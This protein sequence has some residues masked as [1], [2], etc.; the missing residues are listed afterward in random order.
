MPSELSGYP[1][2]ELEF[3]KNARLVHPD[4]KAAVL[5]LAASGDVTDVLV[6][7]H[8]WN[9]DVDDARALYRGLASN[10]R[11]MNAAHAGAQG[12]LANRKTAL[13][14]VLWPSKKFAESDLIPGGSASTG[15][16]AARLAADLRG[17]HGVFDADNAD[18]TLD[19]AAALV[20]KLQT[21]REAQTRY[22]RL[23]R[24]LVSTDGAEADDA[25]S[26]LFDLSAVD[27]MDRLDDPTLGTPAGFAGPGGS[28]AGSPGGQPGGQSHGSGGAAG[29]R[30]GQGSSGPADGGAAAGFGLPNVNKARNLLNFISYYQM[31][32]R[33]GVIG[34]RGLAPVLRDLDRGVAL[35]LVGHSFGARL[36]TAACAGLTGRRAQSLSLLQAAFSHYA[37][38]H[39]WSPGKD[40]GFRKVVSGGV[41]E[42][43]I[44]VTHTRNDVLVGIAYALASR[45]AGQDSSAIGDRDSRFGG[46][47]GNGAQRTPEHV[48]LDL[49]DVSGTYSLTKGQVYNLR[50]DRFVSGHSAI[51]NH[52][53][54]HAVLAAVGSVRAPVRTSAG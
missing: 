13:V 20:P 49:L 50:A 30:P 10:L 39:N 24:S 1:Y 52:Q 8:G 29:R 51:Q 35:H 11:A 40:G 18:E 43:P 6:L 38:A 21:S 34:E 15:A 48:D 36:V 9:N 12:A 23:L 44:I 2:R 25:T 16:E 17:M 37:F 45:V 14:G 26:V 46:L 33:A 4:Q 3:D 41:V 19:R 7:S 54:A 5:A 22:A 42:G 27:L 47:G 53:V 32:T 28:P 31:K